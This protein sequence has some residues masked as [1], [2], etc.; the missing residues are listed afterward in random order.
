MSDCSSIN[1]RLLTAAGHANT[2]K[3]YF[4]QCYELRMLA[5]QKLASIYGINHQIYLLSNTT[6]AVHTVLL[7]LKLASIDISIYG[8][9]FEHYESYASLFLLH[10][11]KS[12]SDSDDS[13]TFVTHVSPMLGKV[14]NLADLSG[15]TSLIVDAAQSFATTLHNELITHADIFCAPLHKH[16]G[17]QIGCGIVCLRKQHQYFEHLHQVLSA[18]ENGV[19]NIDLLA[20]LNKALSTHDLNPYNNAVIHLSPSTID[21]LKKHNI[22]VTSSIGS[23]LVC[24]QYG[25]SGGMYKLQKCFTYKHFKQVQTL[26]YSRCH[27]ASTISN[28][29]DFSDEINA[30]LIESF[31]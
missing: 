7:A 13:V 3:Q 2:P 22:N 9:G 6:Q 8:H 1:P 30:K 28:H 27:M 17:L 5:K 11:N 15:H 18:A 29:Y 26:R 16:A 10:D 24:F 4:K 20:A 12:L 23:P 21:V 14:A 25:D 31:A 19:K